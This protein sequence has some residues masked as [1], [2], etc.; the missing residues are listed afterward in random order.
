MAGSIEKLGAA[1][2]QA[3][4]ALAGVGAR[5]RDAALGAIA[6]ALQANTAAILEAN[7]GDMES[8]RESGMR[9]AL[10]DRLLLTEER[11]RGIAHGVCEVME[12][13]DPLGRSDYEKTRPNGLRISAR[14]VPLGVV[15][16]IYES[17]PNVTVDAAAL[18]LKSG[19][20]VILRGG[21]EAYRSNLALAETMRRALRESGLPEDCVS[22]VSDTSRESVGELMNL[23]GVVDLLIPRGGAGLIKYVCENARV[24]VVQTGVG[25]CHVYVEKTADLEMAAQIIFNAKCSRPSVCNAAE[26]LLVDLSIAAEFLPRAKKLLDTKNT[27]LR[28]CPETLKILPDAKPA[29]ETDWETEYGDYILA[30]KVVS[31]IDEAIEHIARYGSGHSEAIVTDSYEAARRFEDAIDAAAVYVN[32][33]TRFTDGGEFGLGAE[34]GISTQKLHARGPMGVEQLTSLKYVVHGDGQVRG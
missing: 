27:E 24:P 1:A 26:T 5:E 25:N 6:A 8:A 30:V 32:A 11:V 33:S 2:K 14:R 18:C 17:R 9:A 34:L 23:T 22:L 3:S 21:K 31:G 20:A 28:G 4:R 13:P 15:A 12:L 16:I 7:A 29:E 10:L 19:N